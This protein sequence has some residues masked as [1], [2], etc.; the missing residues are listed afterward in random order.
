MTIENV[1]CTEETL[2]FPQFGYAFVQQKD[3]SP[4]EDQKKEALRFCDYT[5][6]NGWR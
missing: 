6:S 3:P 4:R 5:Y 2:M 1:S